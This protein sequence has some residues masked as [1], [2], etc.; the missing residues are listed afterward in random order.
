MRATGTFF[1]FL[2]ETCPFESKVASGPSLV[3]RIGDAGW[4][5]RRVKVL[6]RYLSSKIPEK[7]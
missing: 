7:V 5:E 6:E 2:N 3:S 1:G 4:S